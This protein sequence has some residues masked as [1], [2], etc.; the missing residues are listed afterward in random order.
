MTDDV[1]M[2]KKKAKD[3][4]YQQNVNLEATIIIPNCFRICKT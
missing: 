3:E 4:Q 2:I 1:D